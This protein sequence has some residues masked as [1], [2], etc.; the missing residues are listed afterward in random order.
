MATKKPSPAW[1]ERLARAG[2]YREA[3]SFDPARIKHPSA[4]WVAMFQEEFGMTDADFRVPVSQGDDAVSLDGRPGIDPAHRAAMEKI[5]GEDN[6]DDSDYAR[7]RFGHGKTVDEN[8]A[9]R[10][11]RV[12]A[13]PDLVVHPRDKEDVSAIVAYCVEHTIPVIP[14]GAGSG[15]VL[16]TRADSGGVVL[17][18]RT[19]M[20]K[21]LAINERN[22]TAVVQPGLI[23][24]EFEALLNE[25]P[26]RFGTN[27]AF[28]CGHFPQSFEMASVGG[29]IAALGSG[30]ASTYYG[31]A[32][33]LVVS[34]EYVTPAGT[35]KT[36]D[37]PA[38]ATGPKVNDIMKAA[39]GGAMKNVLAY[40]DGP[41]VSSDFNHNPHSSV[42][43][44][45]CTK[46]SGR[47]VK[48]CSWY[49]NEWGFSNRMLDT[50][51]ALMGA[52]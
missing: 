27:R 34:Q 50:T 47:L 39:A 38:T 42:F 4:G 13:V 1:R 46:V 22:M 7:V 14:Y 32:Y 45:T 21:L 17:V 16:G 5:V 48:V 30:Q 51:V 6:V 29:W 24:S 35:F 43:D 10:A 31:D 9:L 19:H 25:A 49:D 3:F 26:T 23:G 36:L 33:D 11:G 8:L 40:S 18:M 37:Y 44:A 20:N 52:K 41:L 15:T 28:T 2:T 12:A